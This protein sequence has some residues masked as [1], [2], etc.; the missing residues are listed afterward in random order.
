MADNI[1]MVAR[2]ARVY[3]GLGFIYFLIGT[4]LLALSLANYVNINR[5]MIFILDLYGFV[6]MLIFGL[7]YVFAPGLSH[8]TYANY[9]VVEVEIVAMNI[10]IILIFLSGSGLLGNI[11]V[12]ALPIGLVLLVIAVVVHAI[13][14]FRTVTGGKS[15]IVAPTKK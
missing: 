13:N 4:V 8:S 1:S 12:V 2:M 3:I 10:A 5:D 6:T 14:I 7:S 11:S 9:R 15:P